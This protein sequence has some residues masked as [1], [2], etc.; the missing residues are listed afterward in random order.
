MG[1]ERAA[2]YL[3]RLSDAHHASADLRK[4]LYR[5]PAHEK[6]ESLRRFLGTWLSHYGR[7]AAPSPAAGARLHS[8]DPPASGTGSTTYTRIIQYIYQNKTPF[9]EGRFFFK[10]ISTINSIYKEYLK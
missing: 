1:C 5:V 3:A 4:D 7:H 10:H 2:E 9:Y 8:P 6:R